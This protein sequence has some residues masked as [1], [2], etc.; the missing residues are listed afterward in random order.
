MIITGQSDHLPA[1]NNIYNQAVAEGLRTAH[2]QPTSLEKRKEWFN[3]HD[4][5]HPVFVYLLNDLVTGWLSVSDYRSGRGALGEVVEISYYVDYDHH[6]KGIGTALLEHAI[7]FCKEEDYRILISLLISDNV[8][9]IKLLEKF[10]FRIMGSIPA[11]IHYNGE[12]R[13]HLFMGLQL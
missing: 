3:D 7:T 2:T 4:N 5:R 9:S 13:D 6:G 11:A 10:G 1:I 8:A 12:F